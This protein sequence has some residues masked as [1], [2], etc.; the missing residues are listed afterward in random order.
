MQSSWAMSWEWR[1]CR[2]ALQH[3]KSKLLR[4]PHLWD[5]YLV[6]ARMTLVIIWN[7]DGYTTV[8]SYVFHQDLQY[9]SELGSLVMYELTLGW[10]WDFTQIH[11]CTNLNEQNLVLTF[12]S[13]WKNLKWKTNNKW[14]QEHVARAFGK[15][16]WQWMNKGM[17]LI[18]WSSTQT[19][20][21][22]IFNRTRYS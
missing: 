22:S 1:V 6:E 21:S 20:Q 18:R 16:M 3:S 13:S 15:S 7:Q 8:L 14:Y 4:V 2:I 5:T 9:Q 19:I 11:L 10:Y 17:S 12:M